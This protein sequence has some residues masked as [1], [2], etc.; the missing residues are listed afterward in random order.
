[1][2]FNLWP[3]TWGLGFLRASRSG[4]GRNLLGRPLLGRHTVVWYRTLW[5]ASV[6]CRTWWESEPSTD[7]PGDLSVL[8]DASHKPAPSE[9]DQMWVQL[10][11]VL[12]LQIPSADW[13]HPAGRLLGT[14]LWVPAA[15]TGLL[16]SPAGFKP[17]RLLGSKTSLRSSGIIQVF[18]VS[19][20]LWW[21]A[22][23][24]AHLDSPGRT[25]SCCFLY[26]F[27]I[28]SQSCLQA[29]PPPCGNVCTLQLGGT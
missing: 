19:H 16:P 14:D 18:T 3:A 2:T 21:C 10:D 13:P 25:C 29:S 4:F 28:Q 8:P 23:G 6:P 7:K 24:G 1:M 17:Q 26:F 15:L 22:E 9:T 5:T 12:L 11:A 27:L 20:H